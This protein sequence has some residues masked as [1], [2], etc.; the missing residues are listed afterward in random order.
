MP[1]GCVLECIELTSADIDRSH[2]RHVVN[3]RGEIVP[4]I[5]LREVF[6]LQGDNLDSE[7]I[8]IT[9]IGERQVGFVVDRV[10][11]Q[12]QTV[13]KTL[14]KALKDMDGISGATILGN[15]T[16]ALILDV[17]RLTV[18]AEQEELS[19]TG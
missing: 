3:V 7:Q 5:P 12:H 2:G 9:G 1:L 18:Y 13:I 16:V 10:I 6:G 4:Y 8:V 17:N 19:L 11:G 15:G 14:G